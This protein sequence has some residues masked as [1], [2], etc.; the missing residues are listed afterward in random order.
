MPACLRPVWSQNRC[1]M[2]QGAPHCGLPFFGRCF[3]E[4]IESNGA[5]PG[6]WRILRPGITC[7]LQVWAFCDPGYAQK[8][9]CVFLDVFLDGVGLVSLI[10]CESL[11][12]P[13]CNK[14]DTING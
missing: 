9:P 10:V 6:K 7:W 3:L 11:D 4:H 2:D 5:L 14:I 8:R 1:W 13:A 12:I